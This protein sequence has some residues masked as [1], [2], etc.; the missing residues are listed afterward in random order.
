MQFKMNK[1]FLWR[2]DRYIKVNTKKNKQTTKVNNKQN[3]LDVSIII[4][5]KKSK[6]NS[7]SRVN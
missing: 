4:T 6:R 1:F 5:P 2:E 3:Q 7:N